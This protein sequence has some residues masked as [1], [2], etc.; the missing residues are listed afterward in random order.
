M[1]ITSFARAVVDYF[2]S[3][4][5][6]QCFRSEASCQPFYRPLFLYCDQWGKL[7][8][9][10]WEKYF[11]WPLVKKK[12]SQPGSPVSSPSNTSTV[13]V[14]SACGL[15]HMVDFTSSHC[16]SLHWRKQKPLFPRPLRCTTSSPPQQSPN[17]PPLTLSRSRLEVPSKET[18]QSNIL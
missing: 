17:T 3:T 5:Y 7:L 10:V 6:E 15:R 11:E 4:G 18:K 1:I 8:H 13:Q 2:A 14:H 9:G 16:P 12:K